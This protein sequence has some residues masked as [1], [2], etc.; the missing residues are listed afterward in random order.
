MNA[1][2]LGFLGLGAS[3][4]LPPS[5]GVGSSLFDRFPLGGSRVW[6]T[7]EMVHR[8]LAEARAKGLSEERAK[9]F[10]NAERLVVAMERRSLAE[11]FMP[12]KY[13]W[14]SSFLPE[15]YS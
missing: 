14:M 2:G 13:S 7:Y 4:V 5:S 8:A 15:I 1:F 10:Q 9:S 11:M 12:A 3:A 6:K